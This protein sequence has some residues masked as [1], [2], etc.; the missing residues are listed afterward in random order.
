MSLTPEAPANTAG[1][2]HAAAIDAARAASEALL[3]SRLNPEQCQL[4]VDMM[5]ATQDLNTLYWDARREQEFLPLVKQY[6][7]DRYQ[8]F[9]SAIEEV[10]RGIMTRTE[11]EDKI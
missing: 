1:G 9:Q 6:A 5:N 3:A 10:Q 11:M 7:E 8:R 2:R 4:V